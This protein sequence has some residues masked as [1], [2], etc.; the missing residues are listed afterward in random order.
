M[1][2]LPWPK[3]K[4]LHTLILCWDFSGNVADDHDRFK[5]SQH[6]FLGSHKSFNDV[7]VES[8]T[9]AWRKS[10]IKSVDA[11]LKGSDTASGLED[12]L[13]FYTE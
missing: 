7:R 8:G 2:R 11:R 5:Q 4:F 9:G 10:D 12:F 3:Y 1:V 6:H 13:N